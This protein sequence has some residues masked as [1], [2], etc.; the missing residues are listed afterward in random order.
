M[1]DVM[2]ALRSLALADADISALVGTRV[3]VNRIPRDEIEA[4]DT[5]HPPKM[6]VL[7]Q[8]GGRAKGDTLPVDH[9]TINALCYGESDYEADRVRRAVWERFTALSRETH[10][11]VLIYD[12]NTSGGPI[13]SVEPDLVWP[14]ISQGFIVMAQ[15]LEVA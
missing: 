2:E 6:L 1:L 9:P 12:I 8:A 7:R 3:W 4:A 11:D 14:V 15:A 5:F 13:P 10:A